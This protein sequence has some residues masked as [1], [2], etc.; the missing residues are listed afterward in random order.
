MEKYIKRN[1]GDIRGRNVESM[2]T[3]MHRNSENTQTRRYGVLGMPLKFAKFGQPFLQCSSVDWELTNTLA[4]DQGV[5]CRHN[6]LLISSIWKHDPYSSWVK[7][8]V[9]IYF[10][11]GMYPIVLSWIG[12]NNFHGFKWLVNIGDEN[13]PGRVSFLPAHSLWENSCSCALTYQVQLPRCRRILTRY[14]WGCP[15]ERK[16][17]RLSYTLLEIDGSALPCVSISGGCAA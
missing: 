2:K 17:G 12:I 11:L 9:V 10:A 4:L 1:A 15:V 16:R 5:Y 13:D 6:S 8:L 14:V 7:P 3:L